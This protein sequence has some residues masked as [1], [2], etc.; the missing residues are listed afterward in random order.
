[1]SGS[2]ALA[3]LP[4]ERL[5]TASDT[6]GATSLQAF[7]GTDRVFDRRINALRPHPG[8]ARVADNL[9][10]LLEGSEIMQS[11]RECGR[12]QDPYSYRCIPVVHGTVR[13]ATRHARKVV[14]VEAISVTD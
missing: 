6:T 3:L 11:H 1:M 12:I 13:D 2:A 7:L 8:Q 10:A 9:R 4:S 14:E 5:I